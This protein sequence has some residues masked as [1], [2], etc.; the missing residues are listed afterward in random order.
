LSAATARTG[1]TNATTESESADFFTGNLV[2]EHEFLRIQERP[3]DVG[4]HL[5]LLLGNAHV[6]LQLH[7]LLLRRRTTEA[8]EEEFRHDL[9][10]T[11]VQLHQVR[12]HVAA[13]DLTFDRVA[14]QEM[15]RLAQRWADLFAT[16]NR[17][18]R[19]T[20]EC[21]KECVR[22]LAISDLDSARSPRQTAALV[23]RV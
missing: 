13:G 16:A 5:W 15:Q 10:R 21:R 3:E 8:A 2:I 6:R 14:I 18:A 11:Q 12:H 4:V 1:A 17:L 23:F 19:R 20:T 7:K 22:H 9:A